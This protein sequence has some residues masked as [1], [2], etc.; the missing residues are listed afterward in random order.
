SVEAVKQ[1]AIGC[2]VGVGVGRD[3]CRDWGVGE[4]NVV[5][6][7]R[8]LRWMAEGIV[9]QVLRDAIDL[10][11]SREIVRAGLRLALCVTGRSE[12][13]RLAE[14]RSWCLRVARSSGIA[15][16]YRKWRVG[17]F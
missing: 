2:V 17:L 8:D 9:V 11:I 1:V 6:R 15:A 3:N 16:P 7:N 4:R 10:A 5:E 14:H 12:V 13:N